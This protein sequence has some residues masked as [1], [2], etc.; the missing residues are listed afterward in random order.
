M[1]IRPAGGWPHQCA[2]TPQHWRNQADNFKYPKATFEEYVR[3]ANNQPTKAI[4]IM[5]G[6]RYNLTGEALHDGIPPS[7]GRA[8]TCS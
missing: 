8:L 3:L 7:S 5:P 4:C 1:G 6:V 2:Q